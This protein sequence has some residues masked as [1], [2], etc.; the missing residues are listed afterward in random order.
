[1]SIPLYYAVRVGRVPGIYPDW[2]SCQ[3][4]VNG[5]PGA[6]FK[7]FATREEASFFMTP[8]SL[9][10]VPPTWAKGR[11]KAPAKPPK[12]GPVFDASLALPG[13]TIYTDG[14]CTGQGTPKARAGAGVYFGPDD[15]RNLAEPVPLH[16]YA[17]TSNSAELYA[18]VR[19][20]QVTKGHPGRINIV[21][22]SRYVTK[23]MSTWVAGWKAAAKWHNPAL[24]PN[25]ALWHELDALAAAHTPG[26]QFLWVKGHRSCQGNLAADALASKGREKHP[27]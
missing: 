21:S 8:G 26:V 9:P 7:K 11:P 3:A 13:L 20:L 2:P 25:F 27:D 23:G 10:R 16:Q 24:L 15:P 5:F 14:S 4:Q 12:T 18:A 6:Q 1:M 22:D 17:Q 19:A